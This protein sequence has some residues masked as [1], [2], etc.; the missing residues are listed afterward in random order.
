MMKFETE[1]KRKRYDQLKHYEELG[2]IRDIEVDMKRVLIPEFYDNQGNY[3]KAV[4]Y[5]PDFYYYDVIHKCWIAEDVMNPRKAKNK[6]YG[7]KR[8]LFK[9]YNNDVVH[10]EI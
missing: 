7:M 2:L 8:K 10:K 5:S 6:V 4:Y 9:L 3:E 1:E